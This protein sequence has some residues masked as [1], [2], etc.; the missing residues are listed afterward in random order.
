MDRPGD[1]QPS[2]TSGRL[3]VALTNNTNR[4][5][6]QIDEANPR[7]NNKYGHILE[8]R[9]RDDDPTGVQFWWKLILIAGDPQDPT[10]YFAGYNKSQVSR[11]VPGQPGLRLGRQHVDR[12]GW[13]AGELDA[14]DGLFF[15]PARSNEKGHVQ[16][17]LS[18]PVGAECSG[19]VISMETNTILVAVQHPGEVDGATASNVVSHF[20]YKGDG[21]PR[22]SVIHVFK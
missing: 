1:V 10:T 17:F 4:S 9:E 15:M 13:H 14:C 21:Q 8:L 18:V 19:P 22:P 6:E 12:H 7:A 3:F 16:P 11:S 5:P 2:P 20:P